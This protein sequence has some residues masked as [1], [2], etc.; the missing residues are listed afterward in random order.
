[1]IWFLALHLVELR[2]QKHKKPDNWSPTRTPDHLYIHEI[3]VTTQQLA[4]VAQLVRVLHRNHRAVLRTL[5][6]IFRSRSWSGKVYIYS[7]GLQMGVL[8]TKTPN[9][10]KIQLHIQ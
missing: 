9:F 8:K 6:F 4:S 7:L 3:M 10:I 1:M 5:C 2:N